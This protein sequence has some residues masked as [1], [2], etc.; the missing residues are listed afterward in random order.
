[1][2]S[3]ILDSEN[4]EQYGRLAEIFRKDSLQIASFTITEKGYSLGS[5]SGELLA[6]VRTDLDNGPQKPVS[7]M[8]KVASLLYARYL[9]GEKPIAMVSMDNC[10]HNGDKL[11][12]AV[13]AFARKWC[14]A[15]KAEP[16]FLSYVRSGEKVT[17]PWTMI[18][19]ITPRPDASVQEI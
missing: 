7:Y 4:A 11:Y 19:K 6:S 3:C 16:G 18:D 10:S 13:S 14:A 17:F 12:A 1:M 8:G 5:G 9:S 2:E 15:G